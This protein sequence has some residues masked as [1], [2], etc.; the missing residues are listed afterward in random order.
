MKEQL[1]YHV[2]HLS[3]T[4]GERNIPSYDNLWAAGSYI[5]EQFR[6]IED[7][8]KFQE[9]NIGSYPVANIELTL[10]GHQNPNEII[11]IGAHYDSV[12]GTP[13]ANDNASAIAAL[14]ELAKSFRPLKLNRTLKFVAFTCEEPPY[15][16][17]PDMGSNRY[18]KQCKQNKDDIK[19]MI[20][21]DLIG[22]YGNFK[23]E[24]P[25]TSMK[26]TYP[27][28]GNFV[29]FIGDK[30]SG[31]FIEDNVSLFKEKSN[32][33]VE[34][35]VNNG[36]TALQFC[37]WSDHYWFNEFG[38]M[39]V[40]DTAFFR[41]PVYHTAEDTYDKLNYES[42]GEMVEGLCHMIKKLVGVVE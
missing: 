32:F 35:I 25:R 1:E 29:A 34:S 22:T 24:Y 28:V 7:K 10:E 15:F 26:F 17:T 31:T 19:G 11:I 5:T 3:D 37:N 12:V 39:M 18:Y 13:G 23:Q 9:Y 36:H 4:I 8:L 40:T 41:S 2:K 38:S 27:S 16:M 6:K 42:M 33:P 30:M 14:I 21:L 20:C